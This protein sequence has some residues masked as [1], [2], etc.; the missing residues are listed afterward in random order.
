MARDGCF[1]PLRFTDIKAVGE[2][3]DGALRLRVPSEIEDAVDEVEEEE[4][5]EVEGGSGGT[6]GAVREGG[7]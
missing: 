1:G 3:L 5:E 4:R 7:S 6:R 2:Y